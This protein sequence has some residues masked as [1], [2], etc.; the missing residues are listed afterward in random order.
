MIGF[1][2]PR[3]ALN[4]DKLHMKSKLGPKKSGHDVDFGTYTSEGNEFIPWVTKLNKHPGKKG[5]EASILE[6]AFSEV[7]LLFIKPGLTPRAKL[8]VEGEGNEQKVV[9]VASENFNLQIKKK[10]DREEACYKL[11]LE[12][13][14]FDFKLIN[15]ASAPTDL[16]TMEATSKKLAERD[17]VTGA[18]KRASAML[19]EAEKGVH[20]LVHMPPN[21][22]PKLLEKH[23][24]GDIVIDMESLAS[25]LTASYVLQEDDLHKGNIGFYITDV[26]DNQGNRTDKQKF[27]FFKIDHDLMFMGDIMSQK[28]VRFA[29]ILYDKDSFKITAR[30]LNTFPDLHDS[31]NHYWPTQ[32]R[33]MV[34]GDKAYTRAEGKA[35]AALKDNPDFKIGKWQSF[36]KSAVM[37]VDLVGKA[38]TAHLDEQE[39]A[40]KIHM[41]KNSIWSRI[42]QLKQALVESPDFRDY[43]V[44]HGEKAFTTIKEEIKHYIKSSKIDENEGNKLLAQVEENFN[45]LSG[46]CKNYEKNKELS[47]IQKQ[48]MF[49]NYEFSKVDKDKVKIEDIELAFEKFSNFQ[50]NKE[51][52][53]AF[54]FACITLDLIQKSGNENFSKEAE[55]LKQFKKDYLNSN[56]ITTLEEFKEAAD[57]IKSANLP[58]KQQKNEILAVLKEA[59]L[60]RADLKELKR[61]LQKKEPESPSLKFI[62]QLR[63]ESWFIRKCRGTFGKTSTSSMMI[64]E[65]DAKIN[66]SAENKQF[67]EHFREII[68]SERQ[69]SDRL[70]EATSSGF[71]PS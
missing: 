31:G 32:K 27:T 14:K 4:K 47:S 10:I 68:Q 11:D 6:V 24:S 45:T 70:Q 7:A 40:D 23:K 30:D 26:L 37:P 42:G 49:D 39:D 51:V 43:M 18:D 1:F 5:E 34:K 29:N 66:L 20:F 44:K 53:Q 71:K 19:H 67:K 62:N 15:L 65:I 38:L 22:F 36:L 13:G 50:Q 33:F 17:G 55:T 2:M 48:I 25:V 21:L 59:N 52:A 41:V 35:F 3:K 60:S 28:D 64:Q 58:L 54:K 12:D 57:K 8:V 61:E 9:G 56:G 16:G 46:Y 69:Q 63:S